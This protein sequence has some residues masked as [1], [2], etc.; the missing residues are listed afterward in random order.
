M[1]SFQRCKPIGRNYDN[2][3]YRHT[4]KLDLGYA[5]S[6]DHSDPNTEPDPDS[7]QWQCPAASVG[8]HR[9]L[10]HSEATRMADLRWMWERWRRGPRSGLQ[11]DPGL[12]CSE[13]ERKLDRFLDHGRP[14]I[15]RRL[16]LHRAAS[17]AEADELSAV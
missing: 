14:R 4:F 10:Q 16:L 13:P 7:E 5:D 11:L 8:C 6:D 2:G 15:L 9:H 12:G 17:R 1:W 3:I